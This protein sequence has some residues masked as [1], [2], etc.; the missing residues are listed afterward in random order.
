MGK[1]GHAPVL[2]AERLRHSLMPRVLAHV[3]DLAL[4]E[5]VA[6]AVRAEL[7]D[8]LVELTEAVVE[9]L[10]NARLEGRDGSVVAAMKRVLAGVRP[11]RRDAQLGADVRCRAFGHHAAAQVMAHVAGLLHGTLAASGPGRDAFADR[12]DDGAPRFAGLDRVLRNIH[13]KQ[14]H[15][16]LDIDAD[17]P[18]INVGG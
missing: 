13:L 18:R 6:S 11:F 4:A 1:K 17:R 7:A 14:A 15:R 2:Q 5:V 8:L 16:A 12:V 9:K 10:A 3:H